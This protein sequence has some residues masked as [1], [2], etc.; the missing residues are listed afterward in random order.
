M[1]KSK[2]PTV[3]VVLPVYNGEQYLHAAIDS[4][5]SQTFTD[6]ELMLLDDGSTDGSLRIMESYASNDERCVVLTRENRGLVATLNEGIAR[7]RGRYIARMDADDI[8]LPERLAL[9][10]AYLNANKSCVCVGSAVELMDELGR[11]LIVWP[12]LQTDHEIQHE[13]LKGHTA[14]CHPAALLRTDALRASGG[15]RQEMYPAEDLDLWLRLGEMG[16]LSNLPQV[17][18]RYRMHSASISGQAAKEGKQRAAAKRACDEACHRRGLTK[19]TFE[20]WE[21]WRPDGSHAAMVASDLK[22]GWWAYGSREYTT[23]A[24]YGWRAW[25]AR[26]T[27]REAAALLAKSLWY[28]IG[29]KG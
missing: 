7:A 11:K 27:S 26:P 17:L 21:A 20:A 25:R 24:S 29:P 22:F 3:T 28:R 9:Q 13:C 1:S 8:A 12:Q 15:Y 18:L 23:A 14:V 4:V 16:A 19:P 10:V 5:L 6:F 2:E